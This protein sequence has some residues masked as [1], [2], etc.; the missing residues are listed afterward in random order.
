MKVCWEIQKVRILHDKSL[1]VR[2]VIFSDNRKSREISE[3]TKDNITVSQRRS[4]FK[5]WDSWMKKVVATKGHNGETR[6]L[7]KPLNK[8]TG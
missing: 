8:K 2:I 5:L 1:F 6:L 7:K 3:Q 4:G